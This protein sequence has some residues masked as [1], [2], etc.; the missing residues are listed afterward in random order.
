M[1]AIVLDGSA[2]GDQALDAARRFLVDELNGAGWEV[3]V[4]T[5]RQLEIHYCRG[6]FGCWIKAPGVCVIDDDA[7][8]ECLSLTRKAG[9]FSPPCSSATPST[10][11][12]RRL[13]PGLCRP[14][15]ARRRYARKLGQV[16]P[17]WGW[18]DDKE[19]KG[20]P[21]GGQP[22][23]R[24]EGVTELLS[25]INDADLLVLAFPLYVDSPPS[26][27]T[28]DGINRPRQTAS[29]RECMTGPYATF[30]PR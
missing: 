21:A 14:I 16:W 27:V 24:H 19:G 18:V 12:A 13:V 26:A 23:E 28:W 4:A 22:Q 3:D 15:W 7:R 30:S 11:I 8:D 10:F 1:R 2:E 5:L 6:C 9:G 20:S 17:G 29:V 25:V